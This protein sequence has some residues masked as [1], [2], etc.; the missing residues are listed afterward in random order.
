MEASKS[1]WIKPTS[2]SINALLRQTKIGTDWGTNSGK[3]A[4]LNTKDDM[5]QKIT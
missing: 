5:E 3:Y 4:L 2:F 1:K